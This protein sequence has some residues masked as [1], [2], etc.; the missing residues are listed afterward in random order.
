MPDRLSALDASFLRLERPHEHM[1]IGAVATFDGPPPGYAELLAHLG[2]RLDLVPRYRGRLARAPLDA[3]RPVW[4][5]DPAFSVDHH[6]RRTA[7]PSP[8]GRDE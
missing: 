5:E 3:L 7:L 2:G 8:G 6:V 1:H 4:V